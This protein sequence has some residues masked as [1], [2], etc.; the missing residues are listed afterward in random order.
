VAS[1]GRYEIEH[2]AASMALPHNGTRRYVGGLGGRWRRPRPFG[3]HL[4][5]GNW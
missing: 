3:D 5:R 1:G 2:S 4:S